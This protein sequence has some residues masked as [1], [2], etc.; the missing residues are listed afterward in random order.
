MVTH[1]TRDQMIPHLLN[2]QRFKQFT[3][4]LMKPRKF[5]QTMDK[6][7]LSIHKSTEPSSAMEYLHLSQLSKTQVQEVKN[8]IK[9][10][11]KTNLS[12]QKLFN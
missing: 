5:T 8:E 4:C 10:L 2:I 7:Y 12:M 11:F 1:L 9:Q 3:Q 6:T